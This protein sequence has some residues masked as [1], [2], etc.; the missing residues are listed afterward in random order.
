[1]VSPYAKQIRPY[2]DKSKYL[3]DV[4]NMKQV[5]RSAKNE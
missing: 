1:M 2:L 3:K 4:N 5:P